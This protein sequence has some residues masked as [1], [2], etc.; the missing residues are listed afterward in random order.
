MFL[1]TTLKVVF[2]TLNRKSKIFLNTKIKHKIMLYI[3]L[4]LQFYKT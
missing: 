1:K 2:K 3:S 4:S